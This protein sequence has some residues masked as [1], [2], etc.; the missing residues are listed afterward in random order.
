MTVSPGTVTRVFFGDGSRR[1]LY[2]GFDAHVAGS[3]VPT[4]LRVHDAAADPSPSR[5]TIA[6]EAHPARSLCAFAEAVGQWHASR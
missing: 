6:A 4:M 2:P 5:V 3:D 1:G